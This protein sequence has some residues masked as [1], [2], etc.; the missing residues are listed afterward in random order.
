MDARAPR[1]AA[2]RPTATM[3]RADLTE[4]QCDRLREALAP[5]VMA[6]R[7]MI[8]TDDT[9]AERDGIASE[10]MPMPVR[11]MLLMLGALV[12]FAAAYRFGSHGIRLHDRLCI[13]LA[14]AAVAVGAV[15]LTWAYATARPKPGKP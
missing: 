12:L 8:R 4:E 10:V 3:H 11:T 2:R 5:H 13:G 6:A 14:C 1:S 9:R 7:G 15:L